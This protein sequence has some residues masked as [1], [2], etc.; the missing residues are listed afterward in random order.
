MEMEAKTWGSVIYLT[1][2]NEVSEPG[3]EAWFFEG[4]WGILKRNKN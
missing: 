4:R 3:Y 1:A 2:N